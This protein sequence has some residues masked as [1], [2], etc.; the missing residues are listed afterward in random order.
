MIEMKP[1]DWKTIDGVIAG[2]EGRI[3][4]KTK[5]GAPKS[6]LLFYQVWLNY[7][8]NIRHAHENGKKLIYHTTNVPNEI[9]YA[10][11][12]VPVHLQVSLGLASISGTQNVALQVPLNMGMTSEMCSLCRIPLGLMAEGVLPPPDAFIGN[13]AVCDYIVKNA[14]LVHGMYGC[15]TYTIEKP[16]L[17][18]KEGIS[19]MVKQFEELIAFLEGVTDQKLDYDRLEETINYARQ[20]EVLHRGINELRKAVPTPMNSRKGPEL[21]LTDFYF[22]GTP[23]AVEYYQSIYDECAYRV[24]NKIGAIPNEKYRL[25][26]PYYFPT[27]GWELVA[28][29][30]KKWGAINVMEVFFSPWSDLDFQPAS[31]LEAIAK[32]YYEHPITKF[33]N[34]P[35]SALVDEIVKEAEEYSADGVLW[36]AHRSC[37]HMLGTIWTMD[38]A[39]KDKI[40]I[41]I[42]RI[43]EDYADPNVEPIPKM[44]DKIDIFFQMLENR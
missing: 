6:D 14:D 35:M 28:H 25:L 13:L 29:L 39:I 12:L 18:S 31:P 33:Q 24:E 40:G 34:A 36:W 9:L 19:Y 8:N 42:L 22:C 30:E 16:Y 2:F 23:L 15:P 1:F 21:Q 41:P 27:Y 10:F 44:I 11:D 32:K 17:Y 3:A 7:L 37:C 38:E 43:D 5:K 26:S 4:H 20:V